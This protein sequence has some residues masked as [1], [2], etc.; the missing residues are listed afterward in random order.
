MY[1]VSFV[2]VSFMPTS[3]DDLRASTE[4]HNDAFEFLLS[5]IPHKYYLVN[6]DDSPVRPSLHVSVARRR[7]AWRRPR[8]NTRN[9]RTER[10]RPSKR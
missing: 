5:L 3:E 7:P 1:Y 10:R 6:K 2:T 8:A 4:A 9:T